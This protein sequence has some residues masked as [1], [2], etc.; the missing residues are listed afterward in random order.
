MEA[1]QN[2]VRAP[3]PEELPCTSY[4]SNLWN[5]STAEKNLWAGPHNTVFQTT[6]YK[7]NSKADILT[8]G[9]KIKHTLELEPLCFAKE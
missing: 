7:A 9:L 5:I 4:P 6:V 8:T 2:G 1:F 3:N